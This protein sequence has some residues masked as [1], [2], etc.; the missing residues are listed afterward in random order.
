[1]L[2]P[3]MVATCGT[4]AAPVAAPL[5]ST[6]AMAPATGSANAIPTTQAR[7]SQI[8]DMTFPHGVKPLWL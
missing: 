4:A 5:L 8:R 6:C 7:H 2:P 3:A 1:M